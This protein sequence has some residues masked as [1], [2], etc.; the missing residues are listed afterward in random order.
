MKP[1]QSAS[2]DLARFEELFLQYAETKS[3]EIEAQLIALHSKIIK[4]KG[5][6]PPCVSARKDMVAAFK[7]IR[8]GEVNEGL[9]KVRNATRKVGFKL[10][11][12]FDKFNSN[13]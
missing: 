4:F 6:C 10:G 12:I 11:R 9:L 1:N 8:S 2:D 13:D 7:D 5:S 3:P